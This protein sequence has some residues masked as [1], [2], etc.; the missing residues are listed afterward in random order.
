[1]L[2][3]KHTS[4][5]KMECPKCSRVFRKE[6]LYS[7]LQSHQI[8]QSVASCTICLTKCKDRNALNEH[9]KSHT[10]YLNCSMCGYDAKRLEYFEKHL[11]LHGKL[12]ETIDYETVDESLMN[13]FVPRTKFVN[14]KHWLFHVQHRLFNGFY[15]QR[16]VYICVLCREICT[17]ANQMTK[18]LEVHKKVPEEKK[19]F[20]YV[21]TCGE[22]FSN[23]V[24]L[25]HHIFKLKGDHKVRNS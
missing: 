20:C 15:L 1:M 2:H 24:L 14:W 19:T 9:I 22:E 25:K 5:S 17:S 21:C 3:G 16:G 7:H 12:E 11:D 4:P 8:L 6:G 10:R 23:N 18:H 13:Y